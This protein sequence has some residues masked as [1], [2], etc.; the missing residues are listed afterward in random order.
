MLDDLPLDGAAL[1]P[2]CTGVDAPM[3]RLRTEAGEWKD[4][5][6]QKTNRA[7]MTLWEVKCV[8]V[9]PGRDNQTL[10]SVQLAGERPDGAMGQWLVFTDLRCRL[11]RNED[12]GGPRQTFNASSVKVSGETPEPST[13]D[14]NG[15][16][17]RVS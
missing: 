4:T 15:R 1:R 5:G 12:G 2:L 13:S 6:E 17:R 3:G 10:I 11:W 8:V 7:G 9:P 14:S 16:Y